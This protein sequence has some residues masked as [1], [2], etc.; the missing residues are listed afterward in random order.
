MQIM[1]SEYLFVYGSLR[2]ELRAGPW[3][4]LAAHAEQV[5]RGL[6]RGRLFAVGDYPGAVDGRGA[7]RGVSGELY[8]LRDPATVFAALDRYEACGDGFPAPQ[9][10]RRVLRPIAQPGGGEI[11]AW[12]YL[13]N[14]PTA[15]LRP[16]PAG[17]WVKALR[18]R[19]R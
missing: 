16:L 12:I 8:R 1:D 15:N 5:G 10:Y 9:E 17:D 4:V 14:W 6:F 7:G 13:Y 19:R 11:A 3:P 18:R 2:S